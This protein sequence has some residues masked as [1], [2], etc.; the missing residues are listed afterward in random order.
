MTQPAAPVV[1]QKCCASCGLSFDCCAGG[2]WCNDVPLSSE[3]RWA[4][5]TQ[6]ADCLCPSC[7]GAVS[8]SANAAATLTVTGTDLLM[9]QFLRWVA[10]R[11]RTYAD[12]MEAW[13]TSC[14]RQS[15]SEDAQAEGLVLVDGETVTLTDAGRD[16]LMKRLSHNSHGI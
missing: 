11:P 3:V 14:P 9:V 5:R 13:R 1:K 6:Y 4:L 2:C 12:V 15:V 8:Q 10:E 16:A 7:L